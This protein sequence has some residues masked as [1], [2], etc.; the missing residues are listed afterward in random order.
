MLIGVQLSKPRHGRGMAMTIGAQTQ[1][2]RRDGGSARVGLCAVL[3]HSYLGA[4]A[5]VTRARRDV[6][7]VLGDCPA[8]DSVL[9]CLSELVTNAVL[10]S[11]SGV[12]GGHF[13]V[14]VVIRVGE[15]IT[16]NVSDDGG[17]WAER[18]RA[19]EIQRGHG[20][21]IVAGLAS[22]MGVEGDNADRAVWFSHP[23]TAP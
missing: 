10:H 21:D 13:T 8:A 9:L 20:L 23:W 3:C 6:A 2:T 14:S 18:A 4:P 7:E 11:R 17:P 19:E 1:T 12:P 16:V 15:H 22:A 5:Q